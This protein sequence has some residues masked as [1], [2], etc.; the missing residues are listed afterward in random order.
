M[1]EKN[2]RPP[3][4]IITPAVR[5]CFVNVIAPLA[6]NKLEPKKDPIPGLQVLIPKKDTELVESIK[7]CMKEAKQEKFGAGKVP[8]L[9]NPLRD[10]D[11]EYAGTDNEELYAGHYFMNVVNRSGM[12]GVVDKDNVK[13]TERNAFNSGDWA[14]LALNAYGYDKLG[15][16]ISFGLNNIRV[17]KEGDR[18]G[19]AAPRAEDDFGSPLDGGASSDDAF[20]GAEGSDEGGEEEDPFA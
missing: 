8:G 1:S 6:P 12:P 19:G 17:V 15:K 11:K 14:Q 7:K 9:K 20:E 5:C 2:E 3:T 4:Y 16:G 13:I 18:L 10:G